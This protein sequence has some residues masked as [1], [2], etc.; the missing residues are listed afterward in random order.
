MLSH[1]YFYLVS[2]FLILA[3]DY[4]L[5]FSDSVLSERWPGDGKIKKIEQVGP[6]GLA[7]AMS[8]AT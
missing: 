8:H 5:F 7:Q 1:A 3:L 2:H 6:G 4:R